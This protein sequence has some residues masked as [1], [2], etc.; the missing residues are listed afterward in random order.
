MIMIH[1][2]E[3]LLLAILICK[4]GAL[5]LNEIHSASISRFI[6][7]QMLFKIVKNSFNTFS[8]AKTILLH[9]FWRRK[10]NVSSS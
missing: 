3:V 10:S 5:Y 1:L 6:I 9:R 4:N 2:L 8:F 7:A